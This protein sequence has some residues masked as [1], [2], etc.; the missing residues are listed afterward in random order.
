MLELENDTL[1]VTVCRMREGILKLLSLT[2]VNVK[3]RRE[4]E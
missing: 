3:I 2:D 4:Q 1:V